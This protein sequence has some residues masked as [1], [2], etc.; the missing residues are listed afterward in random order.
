MSNPAASNPAA[1][2]RRPGVNGRRQKRL[3]AQVEEIRKQAARLDALGEAQ[4]AAQADALRERLSRADVS[5]IDSLPEVFALSLEALRRTRGIQLYDVQIMAAI[6]LAQG[7]VAEMQTGEGKTFAAVPAAVL[8]GL[9]GRGVHVVTT[10][11]YLADRDFQL[12]RP[13]YEALGLTTSLL[14]EQCPA[15]QK[16]DAYQSDITYG[17]GYEFGFDY[18]RDQVALRSSQRRELGESLLHCLR[19]QHG[20]APSVV[21]RGRAFAIVDEVDN[22]LIDEAGS[23]LILSSTSATGAADAEVHRRV[24]ELISLLEPDRH[25]RCTAA[26]GQVELTREGKERIYAPDIG[27]P[28]ELLRRSWME[29][30]EQ[31]LRAKL[32]FRRDVHY[33]V[34]DQAVHIVDA[35][36]GRIFAD[37]TWMDGLHQAIEAK[38]NLPVTSEKSV[39]AHITR[40]RFFRLYDRLSGMTGTAAGCQRE[41]KTV[42]GLKVA[43]IPL[44]VPSRRVVWPL[45][46]FASRDAK[47]AAIASDVATIHQTGRPILVGTRSIADSE[48]LADTLRSRG[49]PF[50]LLNGRQ[51][52]EEAAVITAAGDRGA[53]TI[54]TNLA[55]RGTDIRLA[56]GVPSL[57]GLHVLVTEPYESSRVDWQLIGRCGRQGD[58][59]SA[60]VYVS[61]DDALIQGYGSWLI[62]P[63]TRSA[64][65]S[66]EVQIDITQR[67]RR[68]QQ[69]AERTQFA[70][71]SA[72]LRRDLRRDTLMS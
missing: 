48:R 63:M 16:R 20:R 33:I 47:W 30:V 4:L 65:R 5:V 35:S 40:Q 62:G 44:R 70:A 27:I 18:L 51:D 31:S 59:G 6:A 1:V 23:P 32:L 7:T 13:A 12:L 46:S 61:S 68:V 38:E 28:V 60:Q 14:P 43:P 22:V 11:A 42:Y 54:S 39:L 2:Q 57:G 52:A 36:T 10:N 72:L 19:G 58:P 25:F 3:A 66:G 50:Q 45:R 69:A 26:S 21:Q 41:F 53:I 29:Y 71:R 67:V 37:R 56:E 8:H 34:K 24:K 17:V 15:N 64:D 9:S 55:G 49:L